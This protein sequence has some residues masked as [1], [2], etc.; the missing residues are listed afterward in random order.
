MPT[1]VIASEEYAPMGEAT[2]RQH[3]YEGL[4]IIGVPQEFVYLTPEQIEQAA[5]RAAPQAMAALTGDAEQVLLRHRD[6]WGSSAGFAAAC[7]IHPPP[8]AW[9]PPGRTAQGQ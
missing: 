5:E 9:A 1:A 3:G 4:P 8:P 2:A 6:R 7:G